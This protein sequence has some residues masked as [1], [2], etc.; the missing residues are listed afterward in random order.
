M[1][2]FARMCTSLI[3]EAEAIN[4]YAQRLAVERDTAPPRSCATRRTRSSSTS[5][6]T[7]STCSGAA[8]LAHGRPAD[9]V[10]GGRH[11]RARGGG[12]GGRGRRQRGR[13][14]RGGRRRVGRRRPAPRRRPSGSL[15]I[16]GLRGARDEPPAPRA[17]ADH[18][19]RL[20]E[21]EE[22]ARQHLTV[23]LA[24]RKLVDFSGPHGWERSATN[25]GRTEP[26]SP[27]P[28]EDVDARRRRVLP[29][30]ET[31][32]LVQPLARGA[33]ARRQGRRRRRP[34]PARRRR[35][36]DRAGREHRGL[37][38][39]AEAGITGSPRRRRTTRSRS[40]TT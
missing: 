15:G 11:P 4:W 35:P 21:L 6:W 9:P 24:A 28:V 25:L 29:L 7:S 18:R 20:E 16:G 34:R 32:A 12:R 19:R 40:P 31:R 17:C 8:A 23:H 30:V 1:R 2:T 10:P 38:R 36:P 14:Q 5:A 13:G 3:E 27:A 26:L 37:P 33:R 22:E 39:L